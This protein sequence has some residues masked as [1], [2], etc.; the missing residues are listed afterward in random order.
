MKHEARTL[1]NTTQ[2]LFT[3]HY[4]RRSYQTL[5]AGFLNATGN[6]RPSTASDKSPAALSRF[7][8]QYVWN[9][10]HLIR[11]VRTAIEKR[12][13]DTYADH[14]G[15]K[16]TLEIMLDLTTLEKTGAFPDLEIHALKDKIGLHLVVLYIVIGQ[17]RFP[18]SFLVWRGKTT[19]SP[20]QLGLK[21]LK[22][23]PAWWIERFTVRVLADSGFDSNAFIDGVNALGFHGVIGSRA[24]R[25]VG[26][27]QHLCNLRYQGTQVQFKSCGTP[28]FAAWFQLRQARG[29][30]VWRYVISTRAAEGK[31]ITRWGK[32]RWRIEAFFKT[33]KSRF[34]LD[35]FGQRTA[36]GAMRFLLLA[37]LAF[38]LAYW[39]ALEMVSDDLKVM[40]DWGRAARLARD[41]LVPEVIA[42][43]ALRELRRVKP[44]L[45]SRGVTCYTNFI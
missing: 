39:I 24:N 18:W 21:L 15:R 10:R 35:Q 45:E 13:W 34:G 22:R 17:Q 19:L 9:A 38:V 41:D 30:M 44:I 20:T 31:T 43:D 14:R 25:D 40:L 3:T 5:I 1:F 11:I 7:L 8:N 36:L 37:L 23:I 12:V 2:A 27:G 26:E 16:P 42:R 33:M 28:V 32:R 29:E 4:Q 6:P